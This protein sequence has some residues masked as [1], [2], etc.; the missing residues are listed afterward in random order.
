MS[1]IFFTTLAFSSRDTIS[2]STRTTQSEQTQNRLKDGFTP[3]TEVSRSVDAPGLAGPASILLHGAH[4]MVRVPE[5]D[6]E[7]AHRGNMN[8]ITVR[9]WMVTDL[10]TVAR[11]LTHHRWKR[12]R[13]LE[14]FRTP[15]PL[16]GAAEV[17]VGYT[18]F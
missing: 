6:A 11:M 7:T 9:R 13:S 16:R 15:S 18:D 12:T 17:P 2:Y 3:F 4:M 1:S 10:F 14:F 8:R 5:A